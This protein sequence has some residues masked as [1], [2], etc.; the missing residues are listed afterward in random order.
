[1]ASPQLEDGYTRIAH[2]GAGTFISHFDELSEG[3]D[4]DRKPAN[5]RVY[6]R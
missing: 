3:E 2:V 5:S 1:M 6:Q 4:S